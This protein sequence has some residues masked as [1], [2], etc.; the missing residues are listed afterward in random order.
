LKLAPIVAATSL[1]TWLSVRMSRYWPVENQSCATLS[2][3]ER[4]QRIAIRSASSYGSGRSSNAFVTLK[5]AV[6]API[7][8]ASDATA[9]AVNAG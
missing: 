3:G 7:P 8:N 9:T 2:P 1:K 4:C 6:L 5:I